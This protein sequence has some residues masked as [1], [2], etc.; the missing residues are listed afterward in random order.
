MRI[1]LKFGIILLNHKKW[2]HEEREK[3]DIMFQGWHLED[4]MD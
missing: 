2:R 1:S 4:E 3:T